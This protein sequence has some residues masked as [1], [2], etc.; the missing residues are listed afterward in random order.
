MGDASAALKDRRP[1]TAPL[2]GGPLGD[3][4][5]DMVVNQQEGVADEG[6]CAAGRLHL[7]VSVGRMNRRVCGGVQMRVR[8]TTMA[9]VVRVS[10]VCAVASPP[11]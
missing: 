8:M 2:V 10:G 1:T 5:A 11:C 9:M 4:I 7:G 3:A 6:E